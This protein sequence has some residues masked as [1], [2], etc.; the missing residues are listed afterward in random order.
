MHTVYALMYC[1]QGNS[2]LIQN[3]SH[4]IGMG[5]LIFRFFLTSIRDIIKKIP[6]E[7]N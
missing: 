5:I 2:R 3:Y 7:A 1:T 4:F 6:S